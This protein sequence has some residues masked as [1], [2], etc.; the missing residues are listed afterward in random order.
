MDRITR[1]QSSSSDGNTNYLELDSSFSVKADLPE[2]DFTDLPVPPE[3]NVRNLDIDHPFIKKEPETPST[4]L[5]LRHDRTSQIPKTNL[6]ELEKRLEETKENLD[7]ARKNVRLLKREINQNKKIIEQK[8]LEL[9]QAREIIAQKDVFYTEAIN[10]TQKVFYFFLSQVFNRLS[11]SNRLAEELFKHAISLK[12]YYLKIG[13]PEN[14]TEIMEEINRKTMFFPIKTQ[15]LGPPLPYLTEYKLSC[16]GTKWD[17][18]N[19]EYN[20][21][22]VTPVT[23]TD[24]AKNQFFIEA[25]LNGVESF[26]EVLENPSL[27]K[28]PTGKFVARGEPYILELGDNK[29]FIQFPILIPDESNENRECRIMT[30]MHKKSRRLFFLEWGSSL[31]LTNIHPE[32]L[33]GEPVNLKYSRLSSFPEALQANLLD[34]ATQF[35]TSKV[36][37]DASFNTDNAFATSNGVICAVTKERA[38]EALTSL[39]LTSTGNE[40]VSVAFIKLNSFIEFVNRLPWNQLNRLFFSSQILALCMFLKSIKSS[41]DLSTLLKI[42]S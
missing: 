15:G 7:K 20:P 5:S 37:L 14:K 22:C 8:D 29:L 31:N 36:L 25:N 38:R 42:N 24:A 1:F 18:L 21:K 19:S 33:N 9:N 2:V 17:I 32:L 35:N 40:D 11:Q 27:C 28:V 4:N 34:R 39:G 10:N 13:V 6:K 3:F 26:K 23:N 30:F 41:P 12:L 16:I